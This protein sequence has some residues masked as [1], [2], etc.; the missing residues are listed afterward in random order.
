MKTRK[1]C[2]FCGSATTKIS[3]EHAWPNWIRPLLAPTVSTIVGTRP[4]NKPITYPGRRDD[5]GVKANAV[6]QPCN[7]G[8]MGR[9][10]NEVRSFLTSM[11]RNG[12]E[13]VLS[14]EQQFSL[15]RWVLKTAMVFEFTNAATPFYTFNDR[16]ALRK[17]LSIGATVIWIARYEGSKFLSTAVVK[18]LQY[19][20]A[21]EGEVSRHPGSGFTL[22]AGQFAAQVLTIRTPP[23]MTGLWLKVPLEFETSVA[24]L[25]PRA[26]NDPLAWPP[27]PS[28][29]DATL[30]AFMGRFVEDQQT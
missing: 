5:M 11:I 1:Q 7:E 12:A 15:A 25:W 6:C 3:N 14:R 22:S 19:D 29:T 16:D 20:L 18:A 10:E 13:T 24:V 30:D 26:E 8:W 9:L 28:L 4:A 21:I 17:G 2:V 27:A 23:E